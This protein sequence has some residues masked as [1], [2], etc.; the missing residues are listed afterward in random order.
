MVGTM[1]SMVK[2]VAVAGRTTDQN[3]GVVANHLWQQIRC[4]D[5]VAVAPGQN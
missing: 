4:N 5:I 2:A 3:L 1:N